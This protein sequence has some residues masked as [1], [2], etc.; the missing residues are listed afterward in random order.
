MGFGKP[1]KTMEKLQQEKSDGLFA[2]LAAIAVLAT[3]RS[4]LLFLP[5]PD[6]DR[7]GRWDYKGSQHNQQRTNLARLFVKEVR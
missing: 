6:Q 1:S 7:K 3:N 2:P 5:V 4:T